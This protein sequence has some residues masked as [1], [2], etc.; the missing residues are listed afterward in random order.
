MSRSRSSWK[1]VR[2]SSSEPRREDVRDRVREERAPRARCRRARRRPAAPRAGRTAL[3]ACVALAAAGICA[4][5]HDGAKRAA[6]TGPEEDARGRVDERDDEDQPERRMVREHAPPR[7]RRRQSAA[8]TSA[9]II[10]RAAVEAVGGDAGDEVEERAAART[11]RRRRSRPSP[12]NASPRARAAGT[13]SSTCRAEGREQLPRLQ[14][15][16]VAVAPERRHASCVE[17]AEARR[18]ADRGAERR[19]ER[20]QRAQTTVNTNIVARGEY[21]PSSRPAASGPSGWR[22]E[23][24][25][26]RDAR[27]AAD[28]TVRDVTAVR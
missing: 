17:L 21:E 12:R 1:R 28:Q 8:T 3:R 5:G 7:A 6:L 24:D 19:P 10:T 27:D 16:E 26:A 14:Q 18:L 22:D 9:T 15:H 23:R 4:S 20:E 2:I 13:R 25:V 11:S